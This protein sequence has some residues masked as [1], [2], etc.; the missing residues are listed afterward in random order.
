MTALR[1]KWLGEFQK[2]L[3]GVL[4]ARAMQID[5]RLSNVAQMEISSKLPLI[6]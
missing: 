3:P 5:R 2:V 4:A 1:Q 6:H